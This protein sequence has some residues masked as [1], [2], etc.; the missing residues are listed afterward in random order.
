MKCAIVADTVLVQKNN[1]YYSM[2]LTYEFLSNRYLKYYDDV[3]LITRVE[4]KSVQGDISGYKITNGKNVSAKPIEEYKKVSDAIFNRKVIE[5]K[6]YELLSKVDYVIVRLPNVLGLLACSICEKY[7]IKYCIEMLACP[8]DG[9]WNHKNK[10]GKI[11]API[12]YY[13]NK[14]AIKKAPNVLYVTNRFLQERY[15]TNGNSISCSDVVLKQNDKTLEKRLKKIGNNDP[16]IKLCTVANVGLKWKGHEYVIKAI[17]ILKQQGKNNYKYYLV[18]NGDDNYLKALVKKLNL[19]NEIIFVGS[20]NHDKVF[21]FLA[22]IDIYIQPSLQEGLPRALI[23]AMSCACPCIGSDAGGIPELLEKDYIFHKKDIK[24][25]VKILDSLDADRLKKMSVRNY[26]YIKKN[27]SLNDLEK[28][29][30][31]FYEKRI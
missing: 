27:F 23:E 7:N 18:G 26:N 6:L 28:K 3:C 13:Y 2:T 31:D 10:S 8:F 17:N 14:K 11:L 12:M 15:P 16:T 19:N 25:I 20:L 21:D 9:Y 22:D 1:D 4:K 5:K 30:C 24:Q 29:R